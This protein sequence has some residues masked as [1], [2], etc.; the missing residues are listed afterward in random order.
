MKL[1]VNGKEAV[2]GMKVQTFRGEEAIL[3]DWYEPGTRSGG[4]GGRVYSVE[5]QLPRRTELSSVVIQ[6]S[7][8][9]TEFRC[10]AAARERN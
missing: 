8:N 6:L 3:L 5:M 2:A 1:F 7:V 9:R 10:D 4:N